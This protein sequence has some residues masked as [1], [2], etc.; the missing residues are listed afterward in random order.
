MRDR[1]TGLEHKPRATV[2]HSNG[3]FLVLGMTTLR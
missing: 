2:Q 1:T 3:Y